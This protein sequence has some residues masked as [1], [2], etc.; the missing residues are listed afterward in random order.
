MR[1][2]ARR[3]LRTARP[4]LVLIRL[5]KPCLRFRFRLL[6]WK[7]LFKAN[8]L[9]SKRINLEA[10]APKVKGRLGLIHRRGL[11]RRPPGGGAT[12]NPFQYFFYDF[13]HKIYLSPCIPLGPML[14]WP[15]RFSGEYRP[16]RLIFLPP[17]SLARHRG[18]YTPLWI[19]LPKLWILLAK[20]LVLLHL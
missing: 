5:R 10:Q 17:N 9:I 3:A 20:P 13:F 18:V 12:V 2:L 15:S 11:R 19:S 8:L 1:P 4:A 14:G 7:V 16:Q 6:G